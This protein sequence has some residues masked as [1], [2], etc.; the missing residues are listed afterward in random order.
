MKISYLLLAEGFEEIEAF[1]TVDMLRRAGIEIKTVS[2]TS[3]TK[4]KG[5][6]DITV[7]ADMTFDENVLSDAKWIILPGGLPGA[8][9]LEEYT[10]LIEMLKKRAA[11]GEN[12]A[13][14][15][16]A[17][18][19]VLGKNGI[20]KGK[21]ATCYPG[22]E[23]YLTDATY[24]AQP[25]EIDGNIITGN[26]PASTIKFASAIIEKSM[27]KEIAD[28]VKKGMMVENV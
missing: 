4:V 8:K 28:A 16:A 7:R 9:H 11:S 17:P 14:I 10:P 1:T 24:T 12:I 27:D 6:H 20:L 15:C 2:I 5:A 21:R 26:G 23:Q 19:L 18:A 22:F 25:V 3:D 13:A